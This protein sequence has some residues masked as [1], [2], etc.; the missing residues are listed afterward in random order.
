MT[1]LFV[2]FYL[3]VLA[4]LALAWYLHGIVLKSRTDANHE[5]L[6]TT[7]HGGGARLLALEIEKAPPEKRQ[8]ALERLQSKFKHP[9]KLVPIDLLP[10][11]LQ[12]RIKQGEDVLYFGAQFFGEGVFGALPDGSAVVQLGPFKDYLREIIEDSISGWMHLTASKVESSIDREA[13]LKELRKNF[14]FPVNLVSLQELPPPVQA[15]FH[16]GEKFVQYLSADFQSFAAIPLADN[17][18]YL[19]FGPLPGINMDP[20]QG[21]TASTVALVMIPAALAILLMLRPMANQL[22]QVENAAKLIAEGKL[23]ARVNETHMGSATPLAKAFNL[24]AGKIETMMRTQRE[25]LQVVSHELRTPLTRMRFGLSLLENSQTEA[26]KQK[27]LKA[28]DASAMDLDILVDELLYYVLIESG[29]SKFKR[30]AADLQKYFDLWAPKFT[31]LYPNLLVSLQT[32]PEKREFLLYCDPKGLERV[33]G[34]LLGNATRYAKSSVTVRAESKDGMTI[35]DVDDDG[36]G[37]PEADRKRV[38][39]PF[40]RLRD[41]IGEKSGGVGLGLA[42]VNRIVSQHGGTVEVLSS[43]KGG[44]RIRTN[45]PDS[46]RPSGIRRLTLQPS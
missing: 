2:Q 5:L 22:R 21:A 24:M 33:L 45:W 37:I 10:P 26:E 27:W 39:E 20:D 9:I 40:I 17:S 25:M 4:V 23:G 35:L 16:S 7:V 3:G 38:L 18:E 29:Q 44:C 36:P 14:A 32:P 43:P 31:E 28:L 1:R 15:R 6:F 30:E 41:A 19:N 12:S 11:A 13:T 8:Q 34:N 46:P 42:L